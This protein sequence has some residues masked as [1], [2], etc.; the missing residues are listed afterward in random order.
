VPEETDTFTDK[1]FRR[2]YCE[3]VRFILATKHTTTHALCIHVN[4]N[5][6]V[7]NFVFSSD[8]GAAFIKS[9]EGREY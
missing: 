8:G 2:V 5:R 4:V 9:A 1:S 7:N 6:M 3:P